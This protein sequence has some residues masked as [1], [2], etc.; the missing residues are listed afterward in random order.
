[1]R[2]FSGFI[3]LL[4]VMFFGLVACGKDAEDI[5]HEADSIVD[6]EENEEDEEVE[7]A[8]EESAAPLEDY[9]PEF[10]VDV[11][12]GIEVYIKGKATLEDNILSLDIESNIEEDGSIDYSIYTLDGMLSAGSGGSLFVEEDGSFFHEKDIKDISEEYGDGIFVTLAF[13]PESS[14]SDEIQDLYA[15][16]DKLTGPFVRLFKD[17]KNEITRIA[18]TSF[19]LIPD[20]D[21][22]AEVEFGEPEWDVPED[23]GDGKVRIE[24]D[25][26]ID[27]NF[28]IIEGKSNLIEGSELI[29]Q[30]IDEDEYIIT[31]RVMANTNP[32][33][34]F[35]MSF[36]ITE[37]IEEHEQIFV[38][39]SFEPSEYE[40]DTVVE[41]YGAE[42]ENISGE[43]VED[44]EAS[45][46]VPVN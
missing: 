42:G 34:S 36:R 40:W 29:F 16:G 9:T 1:M 28:I 39:V 44:G 17:F 12:D 27:N 14:P 10:L 11:E 43:L 18:S 3:F 6:L 7:E 38:R 20:K 22:K 5:I 32:D 45:I 19:F 41:H 35:F 21:G 8:T 15:K 13:N 46:V 23:Y 26:K 2:K 30:L 24:P 33:G 31:P 37:E 25:A 4:A